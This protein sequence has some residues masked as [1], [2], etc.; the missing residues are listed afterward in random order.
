MFKEPLIHYARSAFLPQK[1]QI[2]RSELRDSST[3]TAEARHVRDAPF[4]AKPGR[5]GPLRA[6]RP[7]PARLFGITKPRSP[8]PDRSIPQRFVAPVHNG[9]EAPW[10]SSN[11]EASIEISAHHGPGS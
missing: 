9:S 5:D 10:P 4:A 8:E 7:V 1:A 6:L 3:A 11:Q 2:V